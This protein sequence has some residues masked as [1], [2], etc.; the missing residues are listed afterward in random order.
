MA[1]QEPGMRGLHWA[2]PLS[3]KSILMF[4]ETCEDGMNAEQGVTLSSNAIEVTARAYS[5]EGLGG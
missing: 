1:A 4:R 3:F 5:A 2:V